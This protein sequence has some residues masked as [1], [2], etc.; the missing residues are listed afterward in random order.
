MYI[1]NLAQATK[2]E[3][4]SKENHIYNELVNSK[5]SLKKFSPLHP[6]YQQQFHKSN[7]GNWNKTKKNPIHSELEML[8][9]FQIVYPISK[10]L[11]LQIELDDV[12]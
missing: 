2:A 11:L 7:P 10:R 4:K 5:E 3:N 6:T 9:I 1:T 8:S 12:D